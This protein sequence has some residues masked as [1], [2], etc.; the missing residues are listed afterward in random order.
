VIIIDLKLA[1]IEITLQKGRVIFI[2]EEVLEELRKKST[3]SFDNRDWPR[4]CS[5]PAG[6]LCRFARNIHRM[7]AR[8]IANL[9]H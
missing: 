1:G 4:I 5:D 8:Y 9:F 2:L 7:L 6:F 3:F